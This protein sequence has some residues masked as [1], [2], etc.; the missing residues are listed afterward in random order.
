MEDDAV[1][2]EC[3][4]IRRVVDLRVVGSKIVRTHRVDHEDENVRPLAMRRNHVVDEFHTLVNVR[5]AYVCVLAQDA[6]Q[7]A[8][9]LLAAVAERVMREQ[10][11]SIV[12]SVLLE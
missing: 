12:S 9:A 4:Q 3:V 8:A 5:V 11:G 6:T 2:G 10:E 1:T 7:I